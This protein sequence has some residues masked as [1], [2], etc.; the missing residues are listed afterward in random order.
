MEEDNINDQEVD[1]AF[2]D[3]VSTDSN[4]AEFAEWIKTHGL[5]AYSEVTV[6]AGSL[7]TVI[8]RLQMCLSHTYRLMG[9]GVELSTP[10]AEDGVAV[11]DY[12]DE[13]IKN[14]FEG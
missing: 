1:E 13:E 9:N 3:I 10:V 7:G 6:G 12:K 8:E 4:E 11:F 2:N 5:F 14:R